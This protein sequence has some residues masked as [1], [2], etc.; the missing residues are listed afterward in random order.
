VQTNLSILLVFLIFAVALAVTLWRG[1]RTAFILL[2]LPCII[3]LSEVPHWDLPIMPDPG[4]AF[5]AMYGILLGIVLRGGEPFTFRWCSIDYLVILIAVAQVISSA[6]TENW[7]TGVSSS[8]TMFLGWLGPYF[9]ARL[10]FQSMS[11]RRRALRVVI[12][13]VAVIAF[14]ALIET[15]L[16]PHFYR[17]LVRAALGM[18]R[19][20]T[21]AYRRFDF[22][23]A[24]SAFDHPIY[25]GNACLSLIG[26]VIILAR[27]TGI[28]MKDWRV[29]VTIGAAIFAV[30]TSISYGSYMGFAATVVF[31]VALR[32]GRL[33]R[34]ILPVLTVLAI[35]FVFM[36]TMW[37]RTLSTDVKAGTPAWEGS[38]RTRVLIVK[39]GWKFAADAGLWGHGINISQDELGLKSVDNAYLLFAMRQGWVYLTLWL[40]LAVA[41]AI[42]AARAFRTVHRADL[43]TPLAGAVACLFGVMV[44]L[45]TV[46]SSWDFVSIWIA[47]LG[48]TAS[49]IDFHIYA[50]PGRTR[51]V[52]VSAASPE[53]RRNEP[54]VASSRSSLT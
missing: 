51:R 5:G 48:F 7:Y 17:N 16:W 52:A 53:A 38:F 54:L 43:L 3:L 6:M 11:D 25:L 15:R 29:W 37:M 50:R 26:M 14:F 10:A 41:I 2:G 28:S 30:I 22:F 1:P 47:L 36:V 40:L 39:R 8:G 9:L 21:I 4:A 33:V 34:R 12:F 18:G 24:D 32:Y 45:N 42:R 19:V 20:D 49:L 27:T 13:C 46:W 35:A 23:R 44:A 31:F